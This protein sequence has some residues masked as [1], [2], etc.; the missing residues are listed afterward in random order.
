[1]TPGRLPVR[2]RGKEIFCQTTP[3]GA[4]KRAGAISNGLVAGWA[5]WRFGGVARG[6]VAP[7]WQ[8]GPLVS[9]AESEGGWRSDKSLGS[10]A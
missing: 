9:W 2:E 4:V 7:G 3:T 8:A 10:L 6:S 1:M 5:V